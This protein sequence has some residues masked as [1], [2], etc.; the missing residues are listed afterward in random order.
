MPNWCNNELTIRLVHQNLPHESMKVIEAFRHENPLI[1]LHPPPGG[2]WQYDWCVKNW[3]T[4]WDITPDLIDDDT[5]NGATELRV[6]FHSA[7]SPPTDFYRFISQQ[8]PDIE[9]EWTYQEPGCGFQGDGYAFAGDFSDNTE[10]IDPE[11]EQ[12]EESEPT[13]PAQHVGSATVLPLP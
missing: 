8:H 11:E 6:W 1:K 5:S 10:D 9:M 13:Q 2:E 7:W 4:K 3:G 12:D